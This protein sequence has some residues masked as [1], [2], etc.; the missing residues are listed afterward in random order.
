VDVTRSRNV[1]PEHLDLNFVCALIYAQTKC[2]TNLWSLCSGSA[3]REHV[4]T[5]DRSVTVLNLIWLYCSGQITW[6]ASNC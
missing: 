6:D 3:C 2:H 4:D 5:L 1:E